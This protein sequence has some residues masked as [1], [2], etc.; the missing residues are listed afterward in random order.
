MCR[1]NRNALTHRFV[2]RYDASC[3]IFEIGQNR[4]DAIKEHLGLLSCKTKTVRKIKERKQRLSK[5]FSFLDSRSLRLQN[6]QPYLTNSKSILKFTVSKQK[7][8][9][10]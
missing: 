5:K 3:N 4:I 6:P 2:L 1:Q 10:F 7:C 8:A 9:L